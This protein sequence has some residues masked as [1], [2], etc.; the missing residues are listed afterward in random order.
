MDSSVFMEANSSIYV[1]AFDT[2][3]AVSQAEASVGCREGQPLVR[4]IMLL[5]LDG[6]KSLAQ[7]LSANVLKLSLA[8]LALLAR[9]CGPPLSGKLYGLPRP[10][11]AQRTTCC[12]RRH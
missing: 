12:C 8:L 7:A 10:D 11:T 6:H 3:D 4:M 2:G 5:F 9:L 1:S